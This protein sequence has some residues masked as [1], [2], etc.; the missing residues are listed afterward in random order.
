MD[1]LIQKGSVKCRVYPNWRFG[2]IAFEPYIVL[3]INKTNAY[4]LPVSLVEKRPLSLILRLTIAKLTA[5]QLFTVSSS[6][7]FDF[8][9]TDRRSPIRNHELLHSELTCRQR[10]RWEWCQLRRTRWPERCWT[11]ESDCSGFHIPS[12]E[13]DP[14]RF[15]PKS[16]T[17]WSKY[18]P[19]RFL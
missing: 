3:K 19:C 15:L 7:S 16:T 12:R 6:L 11:W 1:C 10:A 8:R 5:I 4:V 17:I 9:S 13:C 14:L 2:F 18:A